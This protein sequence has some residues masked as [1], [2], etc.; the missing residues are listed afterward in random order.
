MPAAATVKNSSLTPKAHGLTYVPSNLFQQNEPIHAAYNQLREKLFDQCAPQGEMELQTFE[1]YA[2]ALFQSERMRTLELDAQTRYQNEPE[3]DKWFKQFEK[4]SK[5]AIDFERRAD[6]ALREL[7]LLQLDRVS[8]TDIQAEFYAMKKNFPI[9]ASLP[10][11]RM[12]AMSINGT[13]RAAMTLM[14][15][16]S[17]PRYQKVFRD[18]IP[19]KNLKQT[20]PI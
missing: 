11:A 2:Y 6:R 5:M 20:N 13:P 3:S 1:R 17:Q 10:T 4:L 14:V 19:L 18:M 9:P 16:H 8:A 7:R 15:G 12:R